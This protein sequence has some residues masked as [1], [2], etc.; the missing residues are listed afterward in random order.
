M[1]RGIGTFQ[2]LGVFI[3]SPSLPS[4]CHVLLP[5]PHFFLPWGPP[6]EASWGVWEGFGAFWSLKTTWMSM[7]WNSKNNKM[8]WIRQLRSLATD[9]S[10]E[11]SAGARELE[12][13]NTTVRHRVY[14]P[15]GTGVF[16]PALHDV[17]Q[18][19]GCWTPK[20]EFLGCPDIHDTHSG[21]ITENLYSSSHGDKWGQI[22]PTPFIAEWSMS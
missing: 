5:L 19:Y 21:C 14:R 16:P 17:D 2:K 7:L 20:P 22:L 4:F 11:V 15:R 13:P 3:V 10:H 12:A 1:C 8:T 9:K 18:K 6:L